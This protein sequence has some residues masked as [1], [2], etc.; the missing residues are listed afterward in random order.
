MK[1]LFLLLS[2]A[3]MSLP[4]VAQVD[5]VGTPRESI[6]VS[7]F[8]DDGIEIPETAQTPIPPF[9]KVWFGI[10]AGFSYRTAKAM[11]GQ[12]QL[13]NSIRDGMYF[14]ADLHISD[15][16]NMGFGVRYTG[17]RYNQS[18]ADLKINTDY[19]AL[20]LLTKRLNHTETGALVMGGSLGV[21]SYSEKMGQKIFNNSGIG[22]SFDFGYDFRLSKG[23]YFGLKLMLTWG[24]IPLGVRDS[25]GKEIMN[26]MAALDIGVGYRF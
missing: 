21:L 23:A 1:K 12:E 14:G 25:N 7:R 18:S 13:F 8:T 20:S 10:D 22:G 15:S 19:F 6:V 17:H 4:A 26:S 11:E 9:K 24:L 5:S 3:V 16:R 2:A